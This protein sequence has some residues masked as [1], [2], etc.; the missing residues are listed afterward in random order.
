M[1]MQTQHDTRT[2]EHSSKRDFH[3]LVRVRDDVMTI[4]FFFNLAQYKE[5]IAGDGVGNN[6]CRDHFET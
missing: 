5:N 1:Q 2:K 3:I 6:L 4:F